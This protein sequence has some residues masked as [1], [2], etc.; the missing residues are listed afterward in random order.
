MEVRCSSTTTKRGGNDCG[1]GNK[2]LFSLAVGSGIALGSGAEN[3]YGWAQRV[4]EG[5]AANYTAVTFGHA[6]KSSTYFDYHII[7]GRDKKAW[8][9]GTSLW[10]KY[11]FDRYDWE[12]KFELHPSVVLISFGFNNE[13][14]SFSEYEAA[15]HTAVL[16]KLVDNAKGVVQRF[17]DVGSKCIIVVGFYPNNYYSEQYTDWKTRLH[18]SEATYKTSVTGGVTL[19]SGVTLK[20]I[21]LLNTNAAQTD[22]LEWK[23]TGGYDPAMSN[24]QYYPNS[25]GH[26]FIAT[27]IRKESSC[28]DTMPVP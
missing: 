20:Y 26:S 8:T 3:C 18:N 22:R 7:H 28:W 17:N 5:L 13:Y 27:E 4:Q 21:E 15:N 1:A 14:G 9:N 24:S 25:L 6:Y 12:Q 11:S 16:E 23:M 10:L 2:C 19:T